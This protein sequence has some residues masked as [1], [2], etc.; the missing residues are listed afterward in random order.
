MRQNDGGLQLS[1]HLQ[2]HPCAS[3]STLASPAARSKYWSPGFNPVNQLSPSLG[4]YLPRHCT[5]IMIG[6]PQRSY[7]LR[8]SYQA[9]FHHP[10][11]PLRPAR[12]YSRNHLQSTT[13]AKRDPEHIEGCASDA[14]K[15]GMGN[16]GSFS[17][18]S[19]VWR[20]SSLV[21]R[22]HTHR[23]VALIYIYQYCVSTIPYID[24]I[25]NNGRSPMAEKN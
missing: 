12:V 6:L 16:A 3:T 24:E 15:N 22:H 14:P 11:V 17:P 18:H 20:G 19:L 21:C 9:K 13:T 5:I 2:P 8:S 7:Y 4:T 25:W 1:S 10:P 23:R